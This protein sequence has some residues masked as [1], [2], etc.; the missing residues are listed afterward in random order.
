MENILNGILGFVTGKVLPTIFDAVTTI[1]MKL[2]LAVLIF[3]V[4]FFVIKAI[5][6]FV[7]KSPKLEKMDA[8]VRGF[9]A[10]FLAVALYGVLFVTIAAVVG[11]PI[12]S[13]LTVLASCGV[14]IGLA[15]QGALSNFAGGLLILLFKPFKVGDYIEAS[16]GEGFVQEISVVY[17]VILTVDNKRVT[18]PNGALTNAVIKNYSAEETRR[19]DLT[20]NTATDCDVEKTRRVI[21]DVIGLHPLALQDP[22]PF[23]RLSAHKDSSLEYTVRIWVKSADYWTVYFDMREAI[24][25]AFAK[26]GIETPYPKLDVNVKNAK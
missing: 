10:S 23:V 22:A 21:M 20:F 9:T 11:I 4:G 14:A 12:A 16:G 25:V 8:G 26:N 7:K 17:T 3:L 6:K 2:V 15:L 19:V 24:E 5:V 13:L 18:I 1:G